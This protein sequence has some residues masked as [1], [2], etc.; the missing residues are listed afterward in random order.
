MVYVNVVPHIPQVLKN[1]PNIV[2]FANHITPKT[3]I[4]STTDSSTDYCVEHNGMV[5][6]PSSLNGY[7]SREYFGC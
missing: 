2:V 3:V 1:T 7:M 4:Y 6:K 5:S